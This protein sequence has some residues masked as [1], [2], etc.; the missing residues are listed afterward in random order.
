VTLLDTVPRSISSRRTPPGPGKGPRKRR[1]LLR[2]LLWSFASC[3][4][5]SAG[6]CIVLYFYFTHDLPE[7]FTIEDYRPSVLTRIFDRNGEIIGEFHRE[8]R[9][10]IPLSDMP[11]MLIYAFVAAEDNRFFQ[12]PGIDPTGIARALFKNIRA[13][14]KI[15]GGS[16]ITQQ[17]TRSLLLSPEKSYTRKIREL[18]LAYRIENRLSKDDILHIYLNQ[19][20]LGYGTYGVE[21]AAQAY[22]GKSARDLNLSECTLLAG[23]PQAPSRYS[24]FNDEERARNRQAYVLRR[25]T[26]EGYITPDQAQEALTQEIHLTRNAE[27]PFYKAPYFTEHVRKYLERTYGT[28]Q[29]YEGGLRVHTTLDLRLQKLAQEAVLRGVQA[30][31]KRIGYRGPL[32]NVPEEER[33]AFCRSLAVSTFRK[34][35]VI[36]GMVA[37]VDDV[38][39]QVSVCLGRRTGIIRLEHM[40]WAR[41]PNP[42]TASLYASLKQPSTALAPG[43]R[44]LARVL[45]TVSKDEDSAEPGRPIP[46][47][48]EQEPD[49]V[50]QAAILCMDPKSGHILAAVGGTDFRTSQYNRAFQARR[51]PG[52]AFK[53]IVYAAAL[54]KGYTPVSI[55]YDAPEVYDVPGQGGAW[56]PHNY[57]RKFFGPTLFR[58]ALIHSRN[59]VT[60]KLLQN[61]GVDYTMEY[62]RRLGI[63]SDMVRNLSLG[64]GSSEVGLWELVRAY[65]A[66]AAGGYLVK[67]LFI[68]KVMDRKGNLLE[69]GVPERRRVLGEDTAYLM[70]HLMEEVIQQGT[71]RSVR[72]LGRPAAGKTGTTN[73]LK[74]AW[75][76]GYTPELVVGTWVG[77][78][79]HRTM[80]RLETGARAAAPIWLDFMKGALDDRRITPFHPP[81]GVVFAKI[82]P[83]TGALAGPSTKNPIFEC[84]RAGTEPSE[85]MEVHGEPSSDFFKRDFSGG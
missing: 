48:L 21:A 75:F 80:G 73:D 61:I 79:D 16:T 27:D 37:Q 51:Q 38:K 12:H 5:V 66:F 40:A 78:D 69:L 9:E 2:I 18:I 54:D 11:K 77:F 32:G 17:V 46:L 70:T 60:V 59:V 57:E 10:V 36:E 22:F 8:R 62:A 68:E 1:R 15:Q 44:I 3:I 63:E 58:E 81:G 35:D 34:G 26:E 20:Y 45:D 39:K 71:G 43:D 55:I 29:L 84:F 47:A 4:L 19:I 42:N 23:L 49:P 25:M 64:L 74:D 82:D 72:E 67:P 56:K 13:G 83:E 52:S 7:L 65:G 30:L 24:P 76:I 6:L 41:K 14:R 31:D 85:R 33:E 53:P 50:S 28:K